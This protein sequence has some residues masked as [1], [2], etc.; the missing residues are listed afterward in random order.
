M[1]QVNFG[2]KTGDL[3]AGVDRAKNSI[4]SLVTPTEDAQRSMERLN[5]AMKSLSETNI[6]GAASLEGFFKLLGVGAVGATAAGVLEFLH[7][8]EEGM[9]ELERTAK[10]TGLTLAQFQQIK[11]AGALEGLSADKLASGLQEAAKRLNDLGHGTSDLSRFLDANNVKYQDAN[12][13]LI[14]TNQYLQVSAK[15][16]A[17][18]GTEGNKFKAADMLG[19]SR[20]WVA[21]LEKGPAALR[22]TMDEAV[23]LGVVLSDEE[24][25]KAA[26][27]DREWRKTAAEWEAFMKKAAISLTS[28][29]EE[30]I[31]LA[32]LDWENF[33][34]DIKNIWNRIL[35]SSVA[36]LA[37]L[38]ADGVKAAGAA[39]VA[40]QPRAD[41]LADA[42]R[43]AEESSDGVKRNLQDVAGTGRK[44]IFPEKDD[45][46]A[47]RAQLEEMR[48]AI[49]LSEIA[50]TAAQDHANASLKLFGVTE[51][52][53][54]ALLI[55]ELDKRQRLELEAVAIASQIDT[56]SLAAKQRVV[57]ESLAIEAKFV[58]ERQKI[59]DQAKVA[60]A[61]E[62]ESI[63]TPVESAWNAQLRGLLNGTETWAQ[64]TK[65]IISDL[66]FEMIKA[67]E[68]WV[69]KKAA[70]ALA[71]TLGDPAALAGNL[72]AIGGDL[73]QAYAGFAAFLAPVLGPAAPAAAAA[74]TADVGA[75]AVSLS[76]PSFDVGTDLIRSSGLAFVH[77]GERITPAA[78]T[79]PFTGA[80]GGHT[81]HISPV[82]QGRLT[83]PEL[84]ENARTIA[85]LVHRELSIRSPS[86]A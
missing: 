47:I 28:A 75:T 44:T 56:D 8:T 21:V 45:K 86:L 66:V 65:N 6:K 72:K 10:E 57:N 12:G 70:V 38:V 53:K 9:A 80:G 64:A 1:V 79:G 25:K 78:G 48:G 51:G 43:H 35:G 81:F 23:R 40:A 84:V 52:Q 34:I 19:F 30:Q 67:L 58:A 42:M 59:I 15:L 68:A 14:T 18:A 55:A 83:Y 77:Q 5:E 37:H 60:E 11:F 17:N 63:L 4:A 39:L 41:G 74:L 69:V 31:R 49:Q 26:D 22:K 82:I 13:K 32:K 20:E 62:W 85:R 46:D 36:P 7:N 73:G 50:F 16:I 33:V 3:E 24:V 2:A 61:K 71:S 54:T 76:V 27:F 29:I